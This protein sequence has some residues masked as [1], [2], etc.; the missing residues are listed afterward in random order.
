[1]LEVF[2]LKIVYSIIYFYFKFYGCYGDEVF[3][4]LLYIVFCCYGMD[5]IVKSLYIFFFFFEIE[6]SVIIDC[7]GMIY[8]WL[9]IILF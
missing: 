7:G 1:M 4:I 5:D 8:G 9:F 2:L 6:Y 3:C